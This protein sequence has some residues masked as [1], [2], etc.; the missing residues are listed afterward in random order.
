M[1][2]PVYWFLP[3][4]LRW[5]EALKSCF[6]SRIASAVRLCR[7]ARIERISESNDTVAPLL[8]L[9]LGT[10]QST[11]R[12]IVRSV[13]L[14]G[15]QP[16]DRG[17]RRKSPLG[18]QSTTL[19]FQSTAIAYL[20][21][22]GGQRS[23]PLLERELEQM[24]QHHVPIIRSFANWIPG[25]GSLM[26]WRNNPVA[27]IFAGRNGDRSRMAG[28]LRPRAKFGR[29]P[30]PAARPGAKRNLLAASAVCPGLAKIASRQKS[31]ARTRHEFPCSRLCAHVKRS[32]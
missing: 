32:S 29:R 11:P 17:Q 7:T 19:C 2:K 23:Q 30:S 14:A 5:T 12:N 28:Q 8:K 20:I 4:L 31:V 21:D 22:P 27:R 10:R 26:Q 16:T 13:R 18:T 24:K 3:I 1:A 9:F 25:T 6:G 15:L